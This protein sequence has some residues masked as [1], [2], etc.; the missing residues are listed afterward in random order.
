MPLCLRFALLS[1]AEQRTSTKNIF[2]ML[3][4][5][6][7]LLIKFSSITRP[8]SVTTVKFN[9]DP[10]PKDTSG[11]LGTKFQVFRNETGIIFDIEEERKQGQNNLNEV[12]P[13]TSPYEQFNLERKLVV[14]ISS[15]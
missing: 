10:Q 6:R 14:S 5:F 1:N 2:T 8:F 13:Y 11:S 15:I 3:A 7:P 12:E 4:R 9:D